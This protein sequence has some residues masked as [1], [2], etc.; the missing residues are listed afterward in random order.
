VT[1]QEAHRRALAKAADA[2]IYED[3]MARSTGEHFAQITIAAYQ[4]QMLADGWMWTK[5][6]IPPH[7]TPG[8]VGIDP[9][10]NSNA[11]PVGTANP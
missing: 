8:H 1:L 4:T 11:Q 10:P 3:S 2:L 7:E 6:G 9:T 5:A